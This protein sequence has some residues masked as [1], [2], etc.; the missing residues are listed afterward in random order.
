MF[1]FWRWFLANL[2]SGGAAGATSLC[3]AYPLDFARTRLGADIGKGM[4]IL[5]IL[6]LPSLCFEQCVVYCRVCY[7]NVVRYSL[8]ILFSA[9]W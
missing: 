1:Q 4:G 8:K 9:K 2:A 6:T 3:V 7:N 5:E